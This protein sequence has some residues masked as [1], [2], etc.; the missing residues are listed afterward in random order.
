M[1]DN[2]HLSIFANTNEDY[3]ISWLP[4]VLILLESLNK[5]GWSIS[6]DCRLAEDLS[7]YLPVV[8]SPYWG[9]TSLEK[10]S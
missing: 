6:S 3:K 8:V 5:I 10:M 1:S 4:C 7:K 2:K 9:S